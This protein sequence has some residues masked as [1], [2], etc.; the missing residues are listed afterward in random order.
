MPVIRIDGPKIKELDRKRK[1][2][3]ELTKAAAEAFDL[4]QEKIIILIR[5][6]LPENVSVGG[7][8]KIDWK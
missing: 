4:D 1:F 2:V 5:E 6:N 8:L 7:Q 3:R